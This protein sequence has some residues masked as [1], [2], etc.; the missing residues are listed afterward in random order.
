[1]EAAPEALDRRHRPAPTIADP[2]PAPAAPLEAEERAGVDREHG[3]AEG[4]IPRQAIAER[5]RERE[6]PLAYGDVGQDV[7]DQF[8]RTGGHAPAAT[9]RTKPAPFTG[10]GHQRLGVTTIALKTGKTPSPHSTVQE[11]A[12][13]LLEE[14]GQSAGI[15]AGGG[16]KKRFQ[17][18]ADDLMEHGAFGLAGRIAQ[19]CHGR[20]AIVACGGLAQRSHEPRS[21]QPR[22]LAHRSE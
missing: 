16:R 11:A 4:V 1:L 5:V 2:A 13:L 17:M 18:L 20:A 22:A 8:R 7:V 14:R 6:H 15:G 19:G 10:K 9:A 3:A 12:E 21:W